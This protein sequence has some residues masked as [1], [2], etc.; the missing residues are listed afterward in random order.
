MYSA[1]YPIGY[2]ALHPYIFT[3]TCIYIGMVWMFN[4][5][6]YIYV[7]HSFRYPIPF[8]APYPYILTYIYVYIGHIYRNGVDI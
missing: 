5:Y 8:S 7:V 2:S 3:Y 1:P 4:M 6:F